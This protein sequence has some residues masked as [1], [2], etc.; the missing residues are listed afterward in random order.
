MLEGPRDVRVRDA[1]GL[2]WLDPFA[3]VPW[4][5]WRGFFREPSGANSI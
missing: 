3:A 2:P 4:S 5:A 1:R